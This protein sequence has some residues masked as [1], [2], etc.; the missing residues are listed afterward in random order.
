M[1]SIRNAS[2]NTAIYGE[3][4]GYMV[5]GDGLV[6]ADGQRHAMLG[7]LRLETTFAARKLHLGYREVGTT[8]GPF[9][10]RWAAHEFHY[11]TTI[12]AQGNTLFTATDAEGTELTPMGLRDGRLSGSFAHLIERRS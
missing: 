7:L 11:A 10:G 2:H 6:D 4:G 3:C 1:Q 12:H 5:M 8:Y 9:A